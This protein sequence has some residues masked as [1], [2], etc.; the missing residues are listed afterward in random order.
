MAAGSE[1]SQI[2]FSLP[3]LAPQLEWL[4][5]WGLA[6]AA[7]QRSYLWVLSSHYWLGSLVSVQ[8]VPQLFSLLMAFPHSLSK[9]IGRLLT[10]KLWMIILGTSILSLLPHLLDKANYRAIQESGEGTV[11]VLRGV[12][13][14]AT[15]LCNQLAQIIRLDQKKKKSKFSYMLFTRGISRT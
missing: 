14:Q 9:E 3:C 15:N 1:M 2:A 10:H 12:I 5:W 7:W 4:Q 11:C 8:A 13:E 6:G